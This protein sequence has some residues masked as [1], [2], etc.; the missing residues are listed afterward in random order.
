MSPYS[1]DSG[2]K[3]YLIF[4]FAVSRYEEG[5]VEG[6]GVGNWE[7]GVRKKLPVF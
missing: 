4:E 7:L 6:G 3:D 1:I 5:A 2:A